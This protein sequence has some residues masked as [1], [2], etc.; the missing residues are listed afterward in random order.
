MISDNAALSNSLPANYHQR[1]ALQE[2]QVRSHE[3]RFKTLSTELAELRSY[4]P[5]RK[6]KG[7]E[8]EEC[9]LRDEYLEFEVKKCGKEPL[10]QLFLSP[11][12]LK[13]LLSVAENTIRD[14]RHAAAG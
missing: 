2:E 9:R 8:L 7:R 12:V 1:C 10:L 13:R 6:L 3:A 14:L 5:D 11:P 4:T